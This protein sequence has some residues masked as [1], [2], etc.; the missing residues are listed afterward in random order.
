MIINVGSHIS[1]EIKVGKSGLQN[2]F[3]MKD[4]AKQ[5]NRQMMNNQAYL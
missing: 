5:Y 3:F 2:L 1:A 4:R